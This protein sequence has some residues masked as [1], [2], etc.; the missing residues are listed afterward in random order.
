[1]VIACLSLVFLFFL[2]WCLCCALRTAPKEEK[3]PPKPKPV[4]PSENDVDFD[5]REKI[6]FY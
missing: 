1:M 6:P 5:D 4:Q 3:K 2:N